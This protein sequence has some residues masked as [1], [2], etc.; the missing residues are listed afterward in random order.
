MYVGYEAMHLA[1]YVLWKIQ[2]DKV[3]DLVSADQLVWG[4]L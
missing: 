2:S 3:F 1:V 4:G